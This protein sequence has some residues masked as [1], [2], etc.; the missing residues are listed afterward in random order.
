MSIDVII[1]MNVR[2]NYPKPDLKLIAER[3]NKSVQAS[4]R[5]REIIHGLRGHRLP[6][7]ILEPGQRSIDRHNKNR[8]QMRMGTQRMQEMGHPPVKFDIG[9]QKDEVDRM[10]IQKKLVIYYKRIKSN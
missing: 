5:N 4:C 7:K 6:V 1:D 10:M 9:I 2:I 8:S 3:Y